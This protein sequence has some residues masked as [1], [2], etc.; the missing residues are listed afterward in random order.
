MAGVNLALDL[1]PRG[2]AVAILHP[3]MVKTGMGASPQ[4]VDPADSA[5]RLMPRIDEA[6]ARRSRQVPPRRG[7][8]AAVVSG[9]ALAL[10]VVAQRR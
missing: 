9:S 10:N 3:G 7:L 8:R 2:I 4:A 5:R 6:D 1:K